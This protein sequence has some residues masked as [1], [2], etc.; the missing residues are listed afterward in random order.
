MDALLKQLMDAIDRNIKNLNKDKIISAFSF[1]QAAH[2]GQKRKSGEPYIVHPLAV[3]RLL[4]EMG[5]D[6]DTIVAALLHDV[7]EDTEVELCEVESK[8]GSDVAALVDGVTKLGLLPLTSREE[9]QAE[10]VRKMLL[11]MS[12]DIRVVIIKLV[13]RLHNM[14][15]IDYVS[16]QKQRD[17]SLE[18][19]EVYAP[20]AHRLGIRAVKEE[21]EDLSLKHLDPIGYEQIEEKLVGQK[22][23][24][25]EFLDRIK[26]RIR[27]RLGEQGNIVVEGRVKSVYGIYRKVFMQNKIFE[28]IYDIYAV[29]VIVDSVNECYNILGIIHDMFRPIP[30]RFKDYIS[31][32]KPN[33]YQSLHTTVI[34]KEG[35]PFEVQIRTW[36][37]HHT[38][39]Y[40]IAAHWKYKQGISGKNKLEERLVW[41]R[42][43]LEAQ[44]EAEDVEEIVRS[45]K[46][47]I[48]PEEV[49]VFTPKGDVISLPTGSCIID[50]AYAIHTA[51]GNRTVGAKV[52]GKI[53]SLD[54]KVKT[55]EIVEILTSSVK[56]KG[57]SR[58]WIKLVATSEARNKIRNWF[59][60]EYREENIEQG[61]L[62]LDAEFRRNLINIAPEKR[63]EFLLNV[64]KRHHYDNLDDF[65]AAIGYGG[66]LISRI[67]PRVKEDYNKAV[68][69]AKAKNQSFSI[70]DVVNKNK[71]RKQSGSVIVEGLDNCLVKFAKCCSPLP[72]DEVVGFIT[73]G[74]GVSV[75]KADCAHAVEGMRR[76]EDK[77]RWV[78]VHWAS[79]TRSSS[80]DV[81]LNIWANSR[82]N[83]LLDISAQF[84]QMRVPIHSIT[85]KDTKDGRSYFHLSIST[86]GTEHLKSII[87][88]LSKIPDISIVE[89]ATN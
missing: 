20:I 29:R 16:E 61:R 28:E 27:E 84:A 67:M 58:D 52:D 63:D 26:E 43:L 40:G 87:D 5:M 53:V 73:R 21:L 11:A 12:R 57:P 4:V 14:R 36:D 89:R 9:Q 80:Y 10:N 68:K 17:K 66:I 86:E 82:S 47:D 23:E 3:A 54:Y 75:H 37:M 30:N 51:V 74:S 8:F 31:T 46:S 19:M 72:G 1:A 70:E 24:R 45:I 48:A 2:E 15:T 18:T 13:D 50:F 81:T 22:E 32:P 71:S 7:V 60:K 69:E 34:D 85:A 42:Q 64:A 35:V 88:R 38:A 78:R 41:V 65:Y 83:L 44:K 79:V 56:G 62:E 33:M 59:K 76:Q 39:E 6:T 77:E 55:G 25:Q 49:F